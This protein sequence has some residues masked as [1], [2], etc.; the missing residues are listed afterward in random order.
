MTTPRDMQRNKI[1][2][3]E[4]DLGVQ[5][6]WPTPVLH[7]M[8]DQITRTRW[9]K[10]RTT[11]KGVTIVDSRSRGCGVWPWPPSG[12]HCSVEL[13]KDR[14]SELHLLHALAHLIQPRDSV[15]HGPSFAQ[16]YL[17]LVRRFL[18]DSYEPLRTAFR[19]HRVKTQTWSEEARQAA[20]E[21]AIQRRFVEAGAATRDLLARLEAEDADDE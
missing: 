15:W 7:G 13:G 17:H 21:R 8:A 14:Q 10:S 12:S 5:L 9:W 18:P 11:V 6:S 2:A 3:A 19:E 1:Y 16:A 4:N 20:S